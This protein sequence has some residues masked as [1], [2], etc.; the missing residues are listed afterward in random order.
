MMKN[1]KIIHLILM[2]SILC[3]CTSTLL[4]LVGAKAT[5]SEFTGTA[6]WAG[7]DTYTEWVA[8]KTTHR[9][10]RNTYFTISSE[11]NDLDG[12]TL[13]RNVNFNR[14]DH[15]NV[16]QRWGKFEI[17]LDQ[18]V[19]WRGSWSGYRDSN[20]EREESFVGHGVRGD[21]VGLK[22]KFTMTDLDSGIPGL[23]IFGS[24]LNPNK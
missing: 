22:I 2:V 12:S 6:T 19:L 7:G 18:V 13:V 24:V 5:K 8:G 23:D 1:K 9:R 17:I 10:N 15:R 14:N 4:P 11:G 3:I 20:G 16:V 21:L